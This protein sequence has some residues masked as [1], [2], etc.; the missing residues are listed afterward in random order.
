MSEP[1]ATTVSIPSGFTSEVFEAFLQTRDE[2]EWVTERRRE[3]FA[4]FQ[5]LEGEELDPEEWKRV[6]LRAFRPA[7]YQL[8]ADPGAPSGLTTLMQ[9]RAGSLKN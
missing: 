1:T 3:A 4:L 9:D 7:K 5:K 8:Q 6:P 2:P